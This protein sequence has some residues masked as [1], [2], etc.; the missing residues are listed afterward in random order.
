MNLK[1]VKKTKCPHC[2]LTFYYPTYPSGEKG[3]YSRLVKNHWSKLEKM[4]TK[5]ELCLTCQ[6]EADA[7][8][9]RAASREE[10]FC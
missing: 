6:K 10:S 1:I 4:K 2:K 8:A 7:A 5:E 3:N 9:I